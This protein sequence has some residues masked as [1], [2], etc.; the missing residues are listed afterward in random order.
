M[1]PLADD[2]LRRALGPVWLS[3]LAP[4][5]DTPDVLN[6]ALF[7]RTLDHEKAKS[8]LT[9]IRSLQEDDADAACPRFHGVTLVRLPKVTA[10]DLDS[11]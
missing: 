2:A 11:E 10:P 1:S 5:S 4:F 3:G 6:F 7:I 8:I 9:M